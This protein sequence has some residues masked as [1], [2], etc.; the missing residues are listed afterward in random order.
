MQK[1]SA[2]LAALALALVPV[3][4]AL[5][6]ESK[7]PTN[8][9]LIPVVMKGKIFPDLL[10][11]S[12]LKLSAFTCGNGP[13]RPIRF[14]V[15]DMN[16]VGDVVGPDMLDEVA[17]DERPGLIDETDEVVIM[18]KD[19]GSRCSDEQLAR[20][21]GRL[22]VVEAD[23][24][25]LR[26]PGY[27][28][29]L[30]SDR[31]FVPS[32]AAVNYDPKTHTIKTAA[33]LWGYRPESPFSYDRMAF[34][35]LQGSGF[36]DLF[37]RLKARVTVRPVGGLVTIRADEDDFKSRLLGMRVGPVRAVRELDVVVE[38]IPG[39]SV[40]VR[41]TFNHYERMWH[42]QVRFTF[43]SRAAIFTSSMDLQL[44]HDFIDLRGLKFSTS[45]LPSATAVDG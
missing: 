13:P 16:A 26:S 8:T 24:E 39:F 41:A 15:D 6:L 3:S 11:E 33:Y 12:P 2:G 20:V 34:N 35:D 5:S 7:T 40:P 31:G 23:S 22:F 10:G 44:V 21:S 9:S 4:S 43:P 18:L 19:F 17:A 36:K 38:T 1:C 32:G 37:D 25:L 27:V 45:A 42:A 28:Y 30:L 14:Q 29:L